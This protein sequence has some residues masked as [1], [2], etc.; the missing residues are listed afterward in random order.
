MNDLHTR[1]LQAHAAGDI[2]ALADLY[3]QAAA[4]QSDDDARGFFLTHAYVHALEANLPD[5]CRLRRLLVDMGR[6]APED[7]IRA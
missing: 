2:A 6:E 1:L 7:E 3:E 5:A 4:S